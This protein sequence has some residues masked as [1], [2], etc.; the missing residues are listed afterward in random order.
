VADTLA[1]LPRLHRAVISRYSFR[2]EWY[3]TNQG[4]LAGAF[5]L[6]DEIK[7]LSRLIADQ[8][9][10][11][12]FVA[13]NMALIGTPPSPTVEE[14]LRNWQLHCRSAPNVPSTLISSLG[15]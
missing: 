1:N 8:F 9:P 13:D 11:G 4:H 10:D 14:Y 6:T 5:G 12:A 15:F 7:P 3:Q 2:C